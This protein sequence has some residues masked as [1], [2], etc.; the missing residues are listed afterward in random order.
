[1]TTRDRRCLGLSDV[2]LLKDLS[3]ARTLEPFFLPALKTESNVFTNRKVEESKPDP[4]VDLL[5]PTTEI[6]TCGPLPRVIEAC[7]EAKPS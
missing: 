1:M 3:S 2:L 7:C 4:T 5:E 6:H